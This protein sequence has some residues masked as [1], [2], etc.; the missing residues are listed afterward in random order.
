MAWDSENEIYQHIGKF[1]VDFEQFCRSMEACIQTIFEINGLKND[2]LEKIIL[3]GYTADPLRRLLQ[4]LIGE[5][6]GNEKNKKL[7]SKAFKELQ[8]LT[9]ERNDVIHSKWFVYG[10]STEQ[11]INYFLAEGEK[12]HA[13]QAGEATK[14]IDLE[15]ERIEK[16]IQECKKASIIVSL[17]SRCVLDLRSVEECFSIENKRLVI[18]YEALK[19]IPIKA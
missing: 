13:N 19:P 12:L 4:N 17:L 1:C 3:A 16:L 10:V 15:K 5:V 14:S 6:L 7:L 11:E 9:E 2:K 8:S 18:K